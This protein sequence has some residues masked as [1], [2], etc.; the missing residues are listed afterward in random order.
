[1]YVEMLKSCWFSLYE[2]FL[3]ISSSYKFAKEMGIE[4]NINEWNKRL[5]HYETII[6]QLR[7]VCFIKHDNKNE[8]PGAEGR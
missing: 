3:D 1:M 6:F 5:Q 8:R 7:D 4:G 2:I